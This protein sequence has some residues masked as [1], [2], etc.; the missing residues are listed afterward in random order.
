MTSDIYRHQISIPDCAHFVNSEVHCWCLSFSY[1]NEQ[2]G[3]IEHID[4]IIG[5]RDKKKHV[6]SNK[7]SLEDRHCCRESSHGV[8]SHEPLYD[9]S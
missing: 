2:W 3:L 9:H 1:I 7:S 6:R 5:P 4:I 8:T